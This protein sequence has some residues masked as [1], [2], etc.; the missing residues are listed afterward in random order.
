VIIAVDVVIAVLLI[1]HAV[2]GYRQGLVV[3]VLSML[4]FL[5]GGAVGMWVLPMLLEQWGR[6]DRNTFWRSLVLVAGVFLLAT[7]GQGVAVA[8]GSQL[9]STLARRRLQVPDS[10][11]GAVAVTTAISLLLWF[12][13]SALRAGAPAPLARAIGA[14]RILYVID[15][16]VPPGTFGL[17]AGFRAVLDRGD[18]P[19]VF[20]GVQQEPIVEV[21][22]P[23]DS[24][25]ATPA[26]AR[27]A[28]SVV[29][30]TGVATSCRRM[31]EGSGWVVSPGRVVT[32][33]HVVAGMDVPRVRV[34]GTGQ[35]YRASVVAFDSKRDLAVLAVPGLRAPALALGSDLHPGGEAVVAGFPLDGPYRLSP[36]RVRDSIAARGADIYGALGTVRSIY[37]LYTQIEPGNSGGPLLSPGGRVVGV[38]FAK[39]LDDDYTGYA[40]TLDEAG[41]VLRQAAKLSRPVGT[42]SC[43]TA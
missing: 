27:A 26:V 37:S 20:T 17:F 18:F 19:R 42:G 11:L 34:G 41:P 24:V 22:P 40:L 14:S 12:V 1:G 15:S 16:N 25:A 23:G 30:I 43:I 3:S 38:V 5:L 28:A 13:G 31:Q 10:M 7:L 9:R 39:S 21:A 6:V 4:G 35:A 36:A 2:M 29:K 32:N 8:L 33:A